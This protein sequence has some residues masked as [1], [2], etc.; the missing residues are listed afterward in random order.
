MAMI[1]LSWEELLSMQYGLDALAKQ[2]KD[3]LK[4]LDPNSANA[5]YLERSLET[6]EIA[7]KKVVNVLEEV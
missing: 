5:R 2:Q 1:N 3:E 6:I 4:T 7:A